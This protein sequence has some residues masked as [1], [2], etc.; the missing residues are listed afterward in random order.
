MK[1]AHD[2]GSRLLG[3]TTMAQIGDLMRE[4]CDS[5][6][7]FHWRL[8]M[9]ACLPAPMSVCTRGN[10]LMMHR[11]RS[12]NRAV[13]PRGFAKLNEIASCLLPRKTPLQAVAWSKTSQLGRS[14]RWGS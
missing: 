1:C 7:T 8:R 11:P 13:G 10:M 2:V 4:M 5:S 14:A 12:G 3:D 6:G 9:L